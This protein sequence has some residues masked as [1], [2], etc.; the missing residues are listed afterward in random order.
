MKRWALWMTGLAAATILG[1]ASGFDRP[2]RAVTARMDQDGVQ[3]VRVVTHTYW[4]EP[5]RIV[6]K[7][8]TPVELEV[9]NGSFV[10]PHGFSCVVPEVGVDENV[11]VSMFHGHQVVRFTPTESGEY[12]FY[13]PVGSHAKHGM[14]GTLVVEP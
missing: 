11:R 6:V 5:N 14:N 9:Q 4:F 12:P 1:C 3:R 2:V 10:V 8:G 7:R 13:C